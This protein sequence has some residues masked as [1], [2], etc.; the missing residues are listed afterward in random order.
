MGGRLLATFALV[1]PLAASFADGAPASSIK[2]F[3]GTYE[4]EN[5]VSYSEVSGGVPAARKLLGTTIVI[6]PNA[7]D[8]NGDHCQLEDVTIKEVD[9]KSK[10]LE[11]FGPMTL[12]ELGLTNKSLFLDN[13]RCTQVFRMDKYRILFAEDGVVVRAFRDSESAKKPSAKTNARAR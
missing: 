5:I 11:V 2:D 10:V 3:V 1:A 7:I 6:T 8:F 4:I 9:S 12:L 13:A